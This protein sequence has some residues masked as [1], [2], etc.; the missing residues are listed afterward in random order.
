MRVSVQ[1]QVYI[2]RN[3]IKEKGFGW[4][5]AAVHKAPH[6]SSN[7]EGFFFNLQWHYV[8]I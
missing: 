4:N 7:F 1:R 8:A 5:E 2:L 3:C 6:F